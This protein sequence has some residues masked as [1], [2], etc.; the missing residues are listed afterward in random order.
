MNLSTFTVTTTWW[1]SW[2][3]STIILCHNILRREW[4]KRWRQ[5][6][7][8]R[9]NQDSK[10]SIRPHINDNIHK[11]ASQLLYWQELC[12]NQGE[13]CSPMDLSHY[14]RYNRSVFWVDVGSYNVDHQY[15]RSL[16]QITLQHL[17]KGSIRYINWAVQRVI[18]ERPPAD[19]GKVEKEGHLRLGRDFGVHDC[20]ANMEC[21]LGCLRALRNSDLD[22]VYNTESS[23]LRADEGAGCPVVAEFVD[24]LS[25][26]L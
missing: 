21:R 20:R 22:R 24:N 4:L 7:R 3:Y 25:Q 16:V 8:T 1:A 9:M 12:M 15:H 13:A 19:H 5:E 23:Y 14:W 2:C 10:E 18:R 26:L 11:T 6:Y 17:L